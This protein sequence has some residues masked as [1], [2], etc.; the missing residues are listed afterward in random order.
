M[1]NTFAETKGFEKSG[2]SFIFPG[3][4][5]NFFRWIQTNSSA[6]Q[7]VDKRLISGM[8]RML[9]YCWILSGLSLKNVKLDTFLSFLF[10]SFHI[11]M[12]S[13]SLPVQFWLKI[14]NNNKSQKMW[15]MCNYSMK[16]SSMLKLKDVYMSMQSL[17]PH[18]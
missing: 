11:K 14:Y 10:P 9:L 12:K 16:A 7:L 5:N 13:R 8:Q 3:N 4:F 2:C 1:L 15:R 6:V 18:L 17:H